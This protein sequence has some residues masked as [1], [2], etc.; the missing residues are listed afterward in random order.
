MNVAIFASSFYPNLGG[1]EELVRH[2]C[3]ERR[4]LGSRTIVLTNRWPP[5]LPSC[6][7]IDEVPVYRF[8]FRIPGGT[9]REKV[10]FHLTHR[11]VE[12]EIQDLLRRYEIDLIHIQCV[13]T[14][15]YYAQRASE[16]ARVP[17][18]VT[19]QGERTMD[20][21]NAFA[22]SPSLNA[23]LRQLLA[24]A[25]AV[26]AC[27]RSTLDDLEDFFGASLGER[28]SAIYNGVS[29]EEFED[30]LVH[31]YSHP[32]PFI[33]GIGR[34]VPQKGFDILVRAFAR[35]LENHQLEF[36]LLLAGAG[37][38]A[39]HL[40]RMVTNLGVGGRV[41]LLGRVDRASTVALFKGCAFFV[42]PS[43]RE[44]FGIVNLEAM[45]AAKAV[46]ASEV[47][48]VPEVV[49]NGENGVLC[50]PGDVIALAS[51]MSHLASDEALARRLGENGRAFVRSL[52]WPRIAAQY[53]DLY[54]HVSQQ[55]YAINLT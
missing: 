7:V 4:R 17:L 18:I 45:A 29:L 20:A 25:D 28:G 41:H 3:A 46:V 14:N 15:G 9:A 38:E 5:E 36:D 13:S 1:V 40:E 42:L 19:S 35:A 16:Q 6:E 43:R 44:P 23:L 52:A 11:A 55:T 48:G 49:T 47:G 22:R 32:R 54:S 30:Q 27:S 12:R 2:I 33:L 10:K 21:D 50:P 8:P 26:T 24:R 51:A 34:L 37:L 53:E 39:H 31:P